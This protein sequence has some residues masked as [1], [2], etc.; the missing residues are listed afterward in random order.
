MIV[1]N[2]SSKLFIGL[3]WL[4]QGNICMK[5]PQIDGVEQVVSSEDFFLSPIQWAIGDN[6]LYHLYPI[7][8]I[9]IHITYYIIYITIMSPFD[10]PTMTIIVSPSQPFQAL[11][12]LLQISRRWRRNPRSPRCRA[13]C[14][15]KSGRGRPRSRRTQW[16]SGRGPNFDAFE[17]VWTVLKG[18]LYQSQ[19]QKS[20]KLKIEV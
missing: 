8:I 12:G 11:S 20:T 14:W 7:A 10:I 19:I 15:P 3:V 17:H 4:L 16:W 5:A 13:P 18:E 2:A 1:F 9:S 6:E